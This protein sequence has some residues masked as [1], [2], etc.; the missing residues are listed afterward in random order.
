MKQFDGKVAVITGG[1]HGIGKAIAE[2]FLREGAKVYI[3]DTQPG[4]NS[5][6]SCDW[7]IGDIGDKETLEQFSRYEPIGLLLPQFKANAEKVMKMLTKI[8]NEIEKY[9]SM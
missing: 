3:I 2:A 4:E 5:T 7:F 8:K 9:Q 6:P 1:G